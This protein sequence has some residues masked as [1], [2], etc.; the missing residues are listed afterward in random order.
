MV[1]IFSN[2]NFL[3]LRWNLTTSSL[4]STQKIT[5]KKEKKKF[6]TK[7]SNFQNNLPPKSKKYFHYAIC[8]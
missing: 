1:K 3:F 8:A 4:S 6:D 2:N 5:K 7:I